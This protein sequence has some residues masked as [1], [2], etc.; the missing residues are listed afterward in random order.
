M[1]VVVV[2]IKEAAEKEAEA[3]EEE[4]EG[5]RE[6]DEAD[7]ADGAA[8]GDDSGA[9]EEEKMVDERE[10]VSCFKNGWTRRSSALCPLTEEVLL[11]TL[12]VSTVFCSG[13]GV[14]AGTALEVVAP[15]VG[16]LRETPTALQTC[17]AKARVT[18]EKNEF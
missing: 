1:A 3:E 6:R 16:I 17:S 7:D 12:A 10:T 2:V 4:E 8:K 9:E 14:V 11:V 5:E 13:A 15:G 18:K